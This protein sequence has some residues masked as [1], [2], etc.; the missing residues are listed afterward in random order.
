M[1]VLSFVDVVAIK[2][3][4]RGSGLTGVGFAFN[5]LVSRRLCVPGTAFVELLE[6]VPDV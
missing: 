5:I 4:K 6:N 1:S 3:K 2:K